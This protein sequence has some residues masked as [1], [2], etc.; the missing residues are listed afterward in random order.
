[1]HTRPT[2]WQAR[3]CMLPACQS[4]LAAKKPTQRVPSQSTIR[5]ARAGAL[6]ETINPVE[7]Q[8][9]DF[10]VLAVQSTRQVCGW[11]SQAKARAT[12]GGRRWPHL[13]LPL[14]WHDL[15]VDAGDLDAG[16]H[17]GL[18]VGLDKVTRDGRARTSRAIVGALWAWEAALWPAQGPL[19]CRIQQCVLLP[20]GH[21]SSALS[22]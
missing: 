13:E 10:I 7:H 8:E 17:A 16:K 15:S 22:Q 21:T 1:M 2:S 20:H 18:E 19:G 3:D 6:L 14:G 9:Q 4:A 11:E 5:N 12:R